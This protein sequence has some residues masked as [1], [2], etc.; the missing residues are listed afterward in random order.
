[1]LDGVRGLAILAVLLYHGVLYSGSRSGHFI[2][3]TL[4]QLVSFGWSGVDLFFVLSGFLITGILLDSRDSPNYY[5]SFYARRVLRI[6]PLYF[7]FLAGF[8]FVLPMFGR[9]RSMV[10]V[11][12]HNQFWYWTYLVNWRI[13]LEGWSQFFELGH[14]WSL[15]VEEQFYLFWPFVVLSFRPA[16]LVRICI[17]CIVGALVL[18][19]WLVLNG[20]PI[21]AYVLTPSRLDA[22]ALGA[23][24]ALWVR[25]PTTHAALTRYAPRVL[26]ICVVTIASI[27]VLNRSFWP[28]GEFTLT[29]G[30]SIVALA[31]ASL[32]ATLLFR[33]EARLLA[34]IFRS[35]PMRFLGKYS[36]G[37]YVIHHPVI[38]VLGRSRLGGAEWRQWGETEIIGQLLATALGIGLSIALAWLSWH[39]LEA[40]FLRLKK[41]FPYRT[42]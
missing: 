1:M 3:Q 29:L 39:V 23:L 38:I 18:R 34:G 42:S 32:M 27:F 24:L 16:T 35:S 26:V 15:A 20:Y 28:T 5:R 37:I 8:I 36:Y 31:S 33:P 11:I 7:A 40:P 17:A 14:F 9:W 12:Q 19:L 25:D 22:L 30:L 21:G 10:E 6:F 4:R 13:G 41:R 2:D